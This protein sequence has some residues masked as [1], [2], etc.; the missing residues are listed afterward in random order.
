MKYR[1]DAH[2]NVNGYGYRIIRIS[3][4]I[5]T[6]N[7]SIE[8]VFTQNVYNTYPP[9]FLFVHFRRRRADG[10]ARSRSVPIFGL[11]L[12][13]LFVRSFI[14]SSLFQTK[15]NGTTLLECP[16]NMPDR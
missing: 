14:C 10:K 3:V 5:D 12:P 2:L 8:E 4:G 1:I 6:L 13:S 11:P 16:G 7:V 9:L 15:G